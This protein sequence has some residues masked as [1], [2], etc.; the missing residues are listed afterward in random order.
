MIQS[1]VDSMA[2]QMLG[3]MTKSR[4]SKVGEVEAT[5]EVER[6]GGVELSNPV[7]GGLDGNVDVGGDDEVEGSKQAEAREK[8]KV[9]NESSFD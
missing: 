5:G 2:A 4:G 8:V 9:E 3:V 6:R 7:A 1:R